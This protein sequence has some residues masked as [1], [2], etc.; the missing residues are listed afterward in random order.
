VLLPLSGVVW[1]IQFVA[2]AA[3]LGAYTFRTAGMS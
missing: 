1:G 2:T 3:L